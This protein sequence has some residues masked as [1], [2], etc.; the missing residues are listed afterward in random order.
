VG[1]SLMADTGP[2]RIE[3]S[4]FVA[5]IGLF[6]FVFAVTLSRLV[7]GVQGLKVNFMFSAKR[8]A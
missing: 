8:Y 1:A 2:L 3:L 4:I 6:S 5:F 7:Q